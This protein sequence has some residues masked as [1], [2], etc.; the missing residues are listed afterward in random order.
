MQRL[1]LPF[2]REDPRQ[3]FSQ[4]I[5]EEK[6]KR[7]GFKFQAHSSISEASHGK[8]NRSFKGK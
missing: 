6:G 2:I 3:V 1:S 5:L 7:F 8:F 4:K